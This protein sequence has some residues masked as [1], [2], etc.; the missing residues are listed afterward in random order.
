MEDLTSLLP[1]DPITALSPTSQAGG[2]VPRSNENAMTA[3]NNTPAADHSTFDVVPVAAEPPVVTP[4][5]GK[6]SPGDDGKPQAKGENW[7][8]PGVPA[9]T[10]SK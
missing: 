5:S 3:P 4:V 1:S 2:H 9:W 10:N 7:S 8:P 6:V